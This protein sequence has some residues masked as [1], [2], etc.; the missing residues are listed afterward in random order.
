LV[1][2]TLPFWEELRKISL[3]IRSL[4]AINAS[5]IGL[6]IA[7]WYDPIILSS[8]KSNEDIFLI[9]TAFVILFFT[10]TPQWL[11]VFILA[12]SGWGITLL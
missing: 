3:V 7:A 10:K 1:I 12:F 9:L 8:L 6:L 2:G 4:K 11:V 5:V